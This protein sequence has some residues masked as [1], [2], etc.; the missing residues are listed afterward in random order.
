M[1]DLL[2]TRTRIQGGVYEG[3]LTGSDAPPRLKASCSGTEL[4]DVAVAPDAQVPG[5]YSVKLSLPLDVLTEGTQV[6][7]LED[8][9]SGER[10]DSFS[11]QMGV[12]PEDALRG[13]VELLRAE[14]DMLKRAF[15]RHCDETKVD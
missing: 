9:A 10:L 11:V 7:V 2:L 12:A 6:V 15:R 5:G 3:V 14:L 4:G 8:E 1:S 13:E